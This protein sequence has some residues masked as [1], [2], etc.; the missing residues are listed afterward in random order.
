ME[1]FSLVICESTQFYV[2]F[3]ELISLSFY[4]PGQIT[5]RQGLQDETRK[6]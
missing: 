4:Y 5:N 2:T 1:S 3:Y 6:D